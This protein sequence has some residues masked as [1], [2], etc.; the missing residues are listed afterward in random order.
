MDGRL[1][2]LGDC[3]W[4]ALKR[5]VGETGLTREC[6]WSPRS[7][8]ELLNRVGIHHRV[9]NIYRIAHEIAELEVLGSHSR[10]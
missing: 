2:K 3:C 7:R 4:R 8:E 6:S 9:E 5:C 1:N 10:F